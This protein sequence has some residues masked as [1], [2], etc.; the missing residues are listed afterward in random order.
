M[1]N[2]P[3]FYCGIPILPPNPLTNFAAFWKKIRRERVNV[4]HKHTYKMTRSLVNANRFH[5][6]ICV[7]KKI[8]AT[9]GSMVF[10]S[11]SLIT[12]QSK[13]GCGRGA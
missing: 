8:F 2:Y 11:S 1:V 10:L 6:S 12:K 9:G 4:V 13:F 3:M 5:D 7:T